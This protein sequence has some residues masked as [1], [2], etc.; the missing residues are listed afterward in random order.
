MSGIASCTTDH[1]HTTGETAGTPINGTCTDRAGNSTNVTYNLKYDTIAPTLVPDPVPDANPAGWHRQPLTIKFPGTDNISGIA[2]CTA[3]HNHTTGNTTGTPINGFCT[4]RAGNSTD[5]T[6]NLKYDATA[7]TLVPDPV[8]DANPAGWHRQ[9]LTIKFPG[10][11]NMSGIAS[12]TT[13]HN[14]TTGN[15]TGT[16]INGFCTDRAGNRT[17]ATYNLKYDATAP[18]LVPD[19]VPDPNAAGWHRQPLTIKFPGTDNMSGI[20]SC[21]TD[22]NHTTG[23]TTGTPINGFCTDQRRQPH[24]RH[25]Q[26]QIRR[27]RTAGDERDSLAAAERK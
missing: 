10:I 15:T 4:D 25:L 17:D 14:H 13:D 1:T 12:C 11:D 8:P 3:D 6:Y 22:H 23:N 20:A 26:P 2:S 21:T 16:P 7:P 18:T 5:A 19:P 24:R 9:P 27:D